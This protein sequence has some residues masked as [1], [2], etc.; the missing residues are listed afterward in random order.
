M[1]S[2]DRRAEAVAAAAGGWRRAARGGGGRGA[3]LAGLTHWEI[4]SQATAHR[5]FGIAVHTLLGTPTCSTSAFLAS[6]SS[7]PLLGGGARLPLHTGSGG[8]GYTL[9]AALCGARLTRPSRTQ[10]TAA[11][12]LPRLAATRCLNNFNHRHKVVLDSFV[13][14]EQRHELS[15]CVQA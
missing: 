9:A 3:V 6:S 11:P 13:T 2:A 1:T 14:E 8:C 5:P 12:L 15:T 4:P 7:P 10:H